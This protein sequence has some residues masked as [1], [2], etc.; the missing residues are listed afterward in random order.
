[1]RPEIERRILKTPRKKYFLIAAA[2][3]L[4]ALTGWAVAHF[5][6]DYEELSIKIPFFGSSPEQAP[7]VRES[8]PVH[9]QTPDGSAIPV[10]L[11]LPSDDGLVTSDA[12]IAFTSSPIRKAEAVIGEYLKRLPEGM[13]DTRLLG[14]YRDSAST[15]YIDLSDEIRRNFSG[16]VHE[17]YLLLKSLTDTITTNLQDI[18]E[19]RLFVEGKEVESVGGHWYGLYPLKGSLTP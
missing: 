19:V 7:T 13:K 18:S 11:T 17:E 8:A 1:M 16:G 4:A 15:L 2:F 6:I 12:R 3:A 10:T 9:P 5:F 14:C